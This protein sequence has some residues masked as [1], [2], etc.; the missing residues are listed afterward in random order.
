VL[1]LA[2]GPV[3]LNEALLAAEHLERGG[4]DAH[5]V[6][7]PWLNRVDRAWLDPLVEP[8]DEVVVVED[9][10]P[11]GALGTTLAHALSEPGSGSDAAGLA[12]T[13][14]RH[15]GSWRLNGTK[16]WITQGTV[17]GIFVVL[18]STTR[19][20]KQKGI[21]AF[22][23]G[24]LTFPMA[25]GVALMAQPASKLYPK[26]GP[27]RMMVAGF[28]GNLLM[29]GTL[30]LVD[31]GTADLW[32]AAN[33]F[34]RGLSF[35]LM[36]IPLQAA[37][38][39]TISPEATGRASS[40]FNV[41]RQVAGSLGIAVLATIL[42]GRLGAHDA[43]LADPVTRDAALSAFQDTFII[44]AVLTIPGMLV[45]LLMDD[46]KALAAMGR[47]LEVPEGEVAYGEAPG[48]AIPEETAAG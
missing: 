34:V 30:A 32:I 37:S 17:G 28:A 27:R 19:D 10:A 48:Y 20:R 43:F 31:Y 12:T 5:L 33:M 9:H 39:A 16:M 23:V 3:V 1:L 15:G 38:F 7:M 18:A 2:Y 45:A 11:V 44:G 4:V 26:I 46:K 41:S 47:S 8:F 40:I 35:G 22:D 42:T 13:A 14:V 36:I 25:L 24:L 21:S 6:A 29:T